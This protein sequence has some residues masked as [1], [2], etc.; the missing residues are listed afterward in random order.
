MNLT[1]ISE[2]GAGFMGFLVALAFLTTAYFYSQYRYFFICVAVVGIAYGCK[3]LRKQD[4]PFEKHERE[5]RRRT[6]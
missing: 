4:T 6:L 1:W 5:M 2:K 3:Q